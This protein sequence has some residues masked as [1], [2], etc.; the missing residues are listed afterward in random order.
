MPLAV[1]MLVLLA[2]GLVV[3]FLENLRRDAQLAEVGGTLREESPTDIRSV[4]PP[5]VDDRRRC[6]GSPVASE[7]H[8]QLSWR[9]FRGRGRARWER[10][11]ARPPRPTRMGSRRRWRL[12]AARP[13]ARKR[14]SGLA[15]RSPW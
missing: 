9:A 11:K 3:F 15:H 2:T 5:A 1:F 6:D 8:A 14:E 7:R 12:A 10:R 4:D 13:S